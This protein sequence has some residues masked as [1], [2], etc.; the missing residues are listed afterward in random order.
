MAKKI[1][2]IGDIVGK[3]GRQILKSQLPNLI[4]RHSI[5]FVIA[6]GEN[7]ASG[8]GISKKLAHEIHQCGV[9]GITLGDHVWDQIGFADEIEDIPFLCRPANLS[10]RSSGRPYLILE[11][12]GFRLAVI[13]LMGQ[14]FMKIQ[15]SS[16]MDTIDALLPELREQADAIFVE[17]HAE[18]T[19]EKVAMG[20]YLD[21]KVSAVVGTHTHIPTA[22]AALLPLG[23]AYQTDAGMT[24]PYH[25]VLGREIQPILDRMRDGLPRRFPVA[26]DNVQLCGCLVEL[27]HDGFARHIELVRVRD[28][29]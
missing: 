12:E 20:F 9:D 5:D 18:A 29:Q 11:K 22:D 16:P 6:N 7:A 8:A 24:G 10:P 3:P 4:R 26:K 28:Y 14:V 19:S 15:A 21:G 25:S 2:F 27:K 17:V 1:L 23:T 13:T